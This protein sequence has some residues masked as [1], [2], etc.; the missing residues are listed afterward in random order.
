MEMEMETK[1]TRSSP[2]FKVTT[3]VLYLMMVLQLHCGCVEGRLLSL[4][5]PDPND[6]VAYARWL[7]AQNSW[8]SLSTISAEFGGAPF[9]NVMSYSDGL[10]GEGAG[11][12][13]FYLTT[14]DPTAINALEDQRSSLAISEYPIGTCGE[15]DPQNPTCARITLTGKLKLVDANSKEAE[16]ARSALFTK[17][18][19]MKYWPGWHNFQVFKLEIENVFMVN[20]F[21]GRKSI[22]VYQYL[23]WKMSV[24]LLKHDPAIGSSSDF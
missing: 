4:Y 2:M 11:I 16:F 24:K 8:G 13:Y 5:K 10:P 6:V 19:E 7:V 14:L 3:F 21:G 17:H 20:W 1:M 15:K 12:P 18:P 9:G 22:T 23:N